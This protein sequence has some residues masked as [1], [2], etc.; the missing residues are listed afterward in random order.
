MIWWDP[1]HY[2]GVVFGLFGALV[3][4]SAYSAACRNGFSIWMASSACLV[5]WVIHAQVWGRLAMYA[6]YSATSVRDWY[7]NCQSVVPV[8]VPA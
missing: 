4:C 8:T 5:S 3:V 1:P 2:E 6:V 7:M